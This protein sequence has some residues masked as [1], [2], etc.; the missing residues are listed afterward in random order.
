[1]IGKSKK[2][3]LKQQAREVSPVPA[4]LF[5]ELDYDLIDTIRVFALRYKDVMQIKQ[6]LDYKAAFGIGEEEMIFPLSHTNTTSAF[7]ISVARS[8]ILFILRTQAIWSVALSCS[9]TPSFSAYSFTSREKRACACFSVS[10]R[11][12]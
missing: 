8:R 3:S 6:T 12:E 9:V 4:L 5:C 10:A 11:W 1:M 2:K 7:T